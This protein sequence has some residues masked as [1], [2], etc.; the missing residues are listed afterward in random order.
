[1]N[2][3]TRPGVARQ[4]RNAVQPAALEGTRELSTVGQ[5]HLEPAWKQEINR[6]LAAHKSRKGGAPSPN[7]PVSAASAASSRATEAAARVAAR[8][9]K[10]PTYTQLQAEE[11]RLAVRA[12][13]IATK[14]ALE[15]QATAHSALAEMHAAA[16][17]PPQRGPAVVESIVREPRIEVAQSLPEAASDCDA[18]A[19]QVPAATVDAVSEME[20]LPIAPASQVEPVPAMTSEPADR[21]SFDIRWE[22]DLPVRSMERKAPQPRVQEEFELATEDWWTPAEVSATLRSEPLQV[23]AQP[24]HANLIEFPRE[25]VATRKMRPRL[26]EPAEAVASDGQLSIFEVDPGTVSI[27]PAPAAPAD[28]PRTREWNG[29]E[30][31]GIE[32]DAQPDRVEIE[33]EAESEPR[34][35]HL[36]PFGLRLLATVVDGSLILAAF[37]ASAMWISAH[38]RH[39]PAVKTAEAIAGAGFLLAGLAYHALFLCLGTTTPGMKYAGVALCTFDDEVPTR[40]QLRR[41]FGAMLLS[42]LPVGLGFVWS[43]FDDDHLS[44]H[45]RFSATYLRK[46]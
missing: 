39:L 4:T 35:P 1:M 37:F 16:A 18:P 30:W 9:A 40:L 20:A 15:A 10:A 7:S 38:M 19:A 24:G 25:V 32:L 42:L 44:W 5:P 43:V 2:V 13:E 8:F 36:A 14:V 27:D 21:R 34:G 12:A 22:P 46:K 33:A 26:A 6:R 28:E 23:E 29:P 45:D 31:S 41:R 3:C 11:A 17:E